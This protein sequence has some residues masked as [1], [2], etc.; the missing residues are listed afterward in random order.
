MKI[1]WKIV[2]QS[3]GYESLKKTIADE[4]NQRNKYG[5]K[6]DNRYKPKFKWVIARAQH[7]AYH[8]NKPLQ[9][10]LNEWEE[11]RTYNFLNYYQEQKFPRLHNNTSI[12]NGL[13]GI[14]KF[15]RTDGWYKK[16]I[17]GQRIRIKSQIEHHRKIL[18]KLNKDKPRWSMTK[19][20]RG[21]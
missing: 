7:Y 21:Y 8:L 6:G 1:D 20:K 19:K 3:P 10:I 11:K 9:D 12:P 15:Y 2:A 17:I 18:A 4:W 16:D 13:K 5:R 14:I